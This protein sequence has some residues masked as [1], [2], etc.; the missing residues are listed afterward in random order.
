MS[1]FAKI[2]RREQGDD[3]KLHEAKRL[4]LRE[5]ETSAE[6]KLGRR[7]TEEELHGLL[8]I[9]S[10]QLLEACCR[11]FGAEKTSAAEVEKDLRHFGQF[12]PAL[13]T[14]GLPRWRMARQQARLLR[15]ASLRSQ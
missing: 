10:M 1:L 12:C 2:F 14:L 5:A 13:Q 11:S 3:A 7:L 15:S 6:R 4:L 8:W 9:S